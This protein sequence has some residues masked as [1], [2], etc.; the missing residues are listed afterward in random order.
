VTR[1]TRAATPHPDEI[2]PVQVNGRTYLQV[3]GIRYRLREVPR[4]AGECDRCGEYTK[5]LY[6]LSA[7]C[8]SP[9]GKNWCRQSIQAG[10]PGC[11]QR[12][13]EAM[14]EASVAPGVGA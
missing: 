13:V 2:L 12:V 14:V 4:Y 6:F 9:A 7:R 3:R 1:P 11:L 10:H 5:E 8:W